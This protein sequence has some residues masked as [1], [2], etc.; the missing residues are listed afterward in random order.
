MSSKTFVV[1]I[2]ASKRHGTLYVG[3]TSELLN[4]MRQHKAGS[5]PGFTKRHAV[6]KLVHHEGFDCAE[7]A[8]ARERQLKKWRREW[9]INLIETDNPDWQDLAHNWDHPDF[10]EDWGGITP[11]Q[12]IG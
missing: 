3:M 6:T 10:R 1:Y 12:A 11:P 2:L 7:S 8:I 9:K 4:R 5:F